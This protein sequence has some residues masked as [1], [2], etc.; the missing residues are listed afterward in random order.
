MF[1]IQNKFNH[2]AMV[3]FCTFSLK[4]AVGFSDCTARNYPWLKYA[5]ERK[6]LKHAIIP[7]Q[8]SLKKWFV[9][10]TVVQE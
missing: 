5:A 7:A 3:R 6:L 4:R 2:E 9:G 10:S 1:I 8:L